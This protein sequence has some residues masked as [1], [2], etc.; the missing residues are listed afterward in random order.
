MLEVKAAVRTLILVKHSVP[1]IVSDIP[2]HQWHRSQ[3][4]YRRC[5]PLAERLATYQPAAIVT[6]SEPKAVQTAARVAL[7]LGKPYAVMPGLQEHDRSTSSFLPGEAFQARVAG[8]FKYPRVLVFGRETAEQAAGRFART[9]AGVLT[10]YP[11]GTIG[12]IAH[13]TVIALFVAAQTGVEPY[14][15]WQRLGLPSF[16]VLALPTF[17]LVEVVEHVVVEQ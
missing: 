15:L 2:A 16:V 14:A 8:L 7:Y 4:G 9:I 5:T 3:E 12:V 17:E 10:T 13:G 11:H 1:E 6:S